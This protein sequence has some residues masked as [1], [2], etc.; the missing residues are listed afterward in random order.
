MA[1]A[2]LNLNCWKLISLLPNSRFHVRQSLCLV[3]RQEYAAR[4]LAAWLE[5][6]RDLVED[7]LQAWEVECPR[8][9]LHFRSN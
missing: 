7:Q 9:D 8:W 3:G 2:N 6:A 5:A 4:E 1:I